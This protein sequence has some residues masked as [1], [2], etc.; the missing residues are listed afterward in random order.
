[1]IRQILGRLIALTN[2][3]T[4]LRQYVS[5]VGKNKLLQEAHDII[6]E[7]FF[8]HT[9]LTKVT[10]IGNITTYA[11]DK[12]GREKTLKNILDDMEFR[13]INLKDYGYLK[14]VGWINSVVKQ[15]PVDLNSEPIPWVSYPFIHFIEHRLKTD[16]TLFEFGSGAS[17][18]FF[19]KRVS[20]IL[21]AEHDK[22]WFAKVQTDLPK[23]AQLV[24]E[25]LVYNGRYCR[26][27]AET[28]QKFDMIVVD[29][30]D[31]V[32]C[33]I[34]SVAAL[35]DQGVLVL[36]DS[37][38]KQYQPAHEFLNNEGFKQ[39]DFWG[40]APGSNLYKCTTIFYRTSNCL[41]I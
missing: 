15:K 21:S 33:C 38:R 10:S 24:Y 8:F 37:E 5:I 6:G 20:K 14:E 9:L 34:Y 35:N 25:T 19:A 32:N 11:Y 7:D 39:I 27:A 31:R 4:V 30:R 2:S 28:G 29:G 41:H 22:E 18:L 17:T 40:M 1:M 12:F 26:K 13:L 16:F 3:R 36:D 23:N